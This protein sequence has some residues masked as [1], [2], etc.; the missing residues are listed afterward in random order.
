MGYYSTFEVVDSNVPFE[1]LAD[2]LNTFSKSYGWADPGWDL[3]NDYLTGYDGAKWYRWVEDLEQYAL[4]FP[5][6]YIVI[7]R[8]GEESPDMSR[9]VVKNGK[10]IEQVPELTWPEIP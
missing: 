8:H 1:E 6:D 2:R 3:Y 4:H 9:V 7:L 10:A 5:N